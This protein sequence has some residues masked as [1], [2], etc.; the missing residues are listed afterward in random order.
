ME[1]VCTWSKEIDQK[2]EGVDAKIEYP[3]KYLNDVKQLAEKEKEDEL[4]SHY[5][6]TPL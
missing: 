4:Q 5:N 2:I 6:F 1:E 3:R